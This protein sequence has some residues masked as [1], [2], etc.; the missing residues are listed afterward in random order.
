M[1]RERYTIHSEVALA[2]T[3]KPIQV[4]TW[5]ISSIGLRPVWSE[6]CP[7]SGPETSWQAANTVTSM[8]A[9][10]GVAPKVSA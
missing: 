2:S 3:R 6:A 4:P 10:S 7:S 1:I 5:L 8:V 9:W